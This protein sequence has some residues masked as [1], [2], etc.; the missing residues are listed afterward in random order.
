MRHWYIWNFTG[1]LW[2]FWN[3][4]SRIHVPAATEVTTFLWRVRV[5]TYIPR[6]RDCLCLLELSWISAS[7]SRDHAKVGQTPPLLS[8][9]SLVEYRVYLTQQRTL[10][11]S[12]LVPASHI[13]ANPKPT[14]SP[15]RIDCAHELAE[16]MQ[17]SVRKKKEKR[18]K[19]IEWKKNSAGIHYTVP[20]L[21]P[22]IC[23]R[24]C[25]SVVYSAR[26]ISCSLGWRCTASVVP[27]TSP[28]GE[29]RNGCRSY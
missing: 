20:S 28:A 3:L 25:P 1:K 2:L 13:K 22:S 10:A 18:K 15:H 7:I 4:G 21:C 11:R 17:R 14:Y 8:L 29:N 24:I 6:P 19:G 12:R 16:I 27:Q 5:Y 9:S 23:S 26:Q